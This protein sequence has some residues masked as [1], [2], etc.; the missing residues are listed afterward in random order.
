M[1]VDGQPV[2]YH[3]NST[4]KAHHP[5]QHQ[6]VMIRSDGRCFVLPRSGGGYN[7]NNGGNVSAANNNSSNNG[8]SAETEEP[9][10]SRTYQYRKVNNNYFIEFL[11]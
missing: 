11:F 9:P 10:V 5:H 1:D 7:T 4:E 8:G 2:S 6:Q 3:S